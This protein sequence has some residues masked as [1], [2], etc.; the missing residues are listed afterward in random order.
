MKNLLKKTLFVFFA[1]IL[2]STGIYAVQ[3]F[4]VSPSSITQSIDVSQSQTQSFTIENTGDEN[5]SL[6]ISKEDLQDSS[7]SI[8]LNL[9]TTIIEDLTPGSTRNFQVTY[10]SGTNSGN[11]TGNVT[12]ENFDNSSMLEVIPFDVEVNDVQTN[13]NQG[14]LEIITPNVGEPGEGTIRL[15]GELDDRIYLDIR[16]ENI[17]DNQIE[18]TDIET[19]DLDNRRSS[20]RIRS[21]DI[22]FDITDL[23]LDVDQR[24]FVELRLDIPRNIEIGTYTGDL[25]VDTQ[26]NGEFIWEIE[27]E[28]FSNEIDD[29]FFRDNFGEIRSGVLSV[30][31]EPGESIRNR[32]FYVESDSDFDVS[33]ITYELDSDLEEQN[34]A[35][36]IDRSTVTFSPSSLRIRD[37]DRED[38]R[39]DMSIP[40]DTPTGTYSTD[41]NLLNSNDDILDTFRLEVRVIGDI[42]VQS[43]EYPEEIEPG[44]LVDVVVNVRNQGSQ[45]YRNIVVRGTIFDVDSANTDL[46]E[47]SSSF[48]LDS[49]ENEEKTL[50]FR[51]PDGASHGSN[52]LEIRVQYQGEEITELEKIDIV[53]PTENVV[54]ES[55]SINPRT[56]TCDDSMYSYIRVENLGRFTEEIKFLA[57]IQGTNIES[58][59]SFIDINVDRSIQNT[60][61]LDVSSLEPGTYTVLQRVQV[62]SIYKTQESQLVVNEC[63]GS[64]T[65]G[66]DIEDLNNQTQN[67]NQTQTTDDNMNIFGLE[68]EPLTFYLVTGLSILII[69]IIISLFFL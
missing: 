4:T 3:D 27:V 41:V 2:V 39:L 43:I 65:G 50:R 29:I 45:L 31:G 37:G 21:N 14:N 44:E 58:E 66:V 19:T 12:I 7:S 61:V 1:S 33:G 18:I 59:S 6:L 40:R 26:N 28:V 5:I 64:T 10:N 62:G 35:N 49:R 57:Q 24:D 23:T 38:V 13:P 69:L 30:I 55:N 52:T 68:L 42:Y 8:T 48:L 56:I 17:G 11:Y 22:S 25:I 54:F 20:D 67:G 9:G 15:S 51:I 53:R 63:G 36:S 34:S 60:Q 46:S 16:F 47:V 32:I